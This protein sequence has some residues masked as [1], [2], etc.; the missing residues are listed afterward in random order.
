MHN[1]VKFHKNEVAVAREPFIFESGKFAKQ[2]AGA[3]W[4]RWGDSIVLVTVCSSGK[5]REGADFFPLTCEYLEKTY[6][7]GRIPGGFFKR[8]TK[9][10]DAEILNARLIDRSIR[11][12]FP[13]GFFEEVQVIATVVSHDGIHDT[14]VLALNAASMALHLSPLPFSLTSG[15]ISGVRV[16]RIDGKWIAHPTLPQLAQSDVDIMVSSHKDAIVMVEGGAQE[17]SEEELVDALFFA[18]NEG[19][20]IIQACEDMREH[21]GKEKIIFTPASVNQDLY[22]KVKSASAASGLNEALATKEKLDRYAKI[23]ACK[24]SVLEKISQ[25]LGESDASENAK[26]IGDYFSDIKKY[27]MRH[28]VLDDKV[29]IDG[30]GYEEIRPICCEVGL[31]PRTHGSAMFTRGETQGLVSVTLGTGDDEQ[32]IDSLMGE[33]FRKFMLHYNFPPFSVGE[34]RMLRGTSRREI[35]HGALAERAVAAMTPQD[36]ASFPYTIRVVSEILE[37]NGSSSMAT[38]CGATLAMWDAG[39]K[40]KAPVAGIA[41]GMIKEGDKFAVLSDILGD[42]DHLGDMDFKVCGTQNGVTAIQ[43]D[44]KIDGLSREILSKA[45]EQAR[46][47]RLHILGEMKKALSKERDEVSPNA[48]RIYRFKINPD[49]IRDVI[50]PGGRIIRDIIARSGAKVEVSDDG[51]IQVAGVGK[52]SVDSAVSMI[53]DLTR[54]AEIN[55]V[56]KGLVRKILEFGAFIELFPGTEGLCHI[57]ELSDKRVDKVSDVLQE[58]DEVNVVV[59]NIDREGKIRLSRKKA[60]GKQAGDVI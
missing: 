51:T 58:G 18:Q 10:R 45:L 41:M 39:I 53:N 21:M 48:P 50:G 3:V 16:G 59:L 23:D 26:R 24:E 8:E 20:K 47:G 14:D 1:S 42:E 37:S 22:E 55:K 35:G 25:E 6:A 11:P 32:K 7:A 38:V 27:L 4:A 43:M 2:T 15:P 30:R 28:Q 29:R 33:T 36:D 60:I 56:Y 34:A 54:E 40:L 49:K 52:K 17:L 57:S 9:P 12:L 13:D 46:L 31:L 19:L 5:A 44:I